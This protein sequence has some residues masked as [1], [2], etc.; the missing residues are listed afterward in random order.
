MIN[1]AIDLVLLLACASIVAL[2]FVGWPH[3][4]QSVSAAEPAEHRT[5]LSVWPTLATILGILIAAAR[6]RN[7]LTASQ[8][9]A[10]LDSVLLFATLIV[11]AAAISL[12]GLRAYW[13]RRPAR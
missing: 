3:P 4:P 9:Q 11:L 13:R 1:A 8:S 7:D 6:L 12:W 10:P 5:T 2:R